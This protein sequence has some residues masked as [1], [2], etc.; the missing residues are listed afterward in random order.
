MSENHESNQRIEPMNRM[1]ESSERI[2]SMNRTND[3]NQRVES[4][5]RIN[6]NRQTENKQRQTGR[7]H[8]EERTTGSFCSC[9]F[10]KPF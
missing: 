6:E 10:L 4:T 1:N 9:D 3:S 5:S 2:E 7:L 8:T